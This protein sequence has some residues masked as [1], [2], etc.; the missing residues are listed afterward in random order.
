MLRHCKND[1]YFKNLYRI[2]TKQLSIKYTQNNQSDIYYVENTKRAERTSS[3]GR[4][5]TRDNFIS[6]CLSEWLSNTG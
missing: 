4:F 1:S 6:A 3:S 2:R 5:P